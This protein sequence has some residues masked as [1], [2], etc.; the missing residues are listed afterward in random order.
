MRGLG[1]NAYRFS[2]AWGRILPQGTDTVNPRGLDFYDR[3]LDRVLAHGMEPM[4]T[5]YHWDLPAALDD[6]GGWLN[7]DIAEWFADYAQIIFRRFDDRVKL[8]VTRRFTLSLAEFV[9]VT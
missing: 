4:V 3:L 5:L 9:V 8:W 2:I 7:R 6:R 1:L